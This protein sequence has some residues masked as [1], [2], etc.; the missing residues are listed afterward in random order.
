MKLAKL[1]HA[2]LSNPEL[3]LALESHSINV[4]GS[5]R[6][7]VEAAAEVMR[8]SRKVSDSGGIL[9]KPGHNRGLIGGPDGWAWKED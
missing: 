3:R 6:F 8:Y 7:E 2:A 9:V 4:P 1:I 5:S